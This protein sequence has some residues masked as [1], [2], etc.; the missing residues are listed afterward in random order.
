MNAFNSADPL[1]KVLVVV[2]ILVVG[3]TLYGRWTGQSFG[4]VNLLGKNA[5]GDQILAQ[6]AA[7]QARVQGRLHT[8]VAQP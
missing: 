3:T 6:Q 2:I 4:P 1:V 5:I 8:A 7:W